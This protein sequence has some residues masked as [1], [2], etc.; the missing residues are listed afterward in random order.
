MYKIMSADESKME[1]L[2]EFFSHIPNF[3]VLVEWLP[4][5]ERQSHYSL[6]LLEWFVTNYAKQYSIVYP[7]KK[8]D[9]IKHVFVWEDYNSALKGNRKKTFDPFRRSGKDKSGKKLNRRIELE[10]DDNK[11]IQTTICQLNFFKW[12]IKNGI[13]DYIKA[14]LDEIFADMK[15]RS[16]KMDINPDKK[17]KKQ[18]S[19]SIS[20]KLGIHNLKV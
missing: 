12:A 2:L 8:G 14:H 10:Y 4:E 17:Q 11:K 5:D 16:G 20:K 1:D 6:S 18:L 13:L 9:V 19:E 3:D 15:A 7:L